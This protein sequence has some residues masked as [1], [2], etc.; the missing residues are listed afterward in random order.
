M[1]QEKEEEDGVDAS[2]RRLEDNIKK[3]KERLIRKT[4]N[5]HKRH[6]DEQNN[7]S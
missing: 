2:I 4:R 7:K 1:C 3:N 5:K 6:E